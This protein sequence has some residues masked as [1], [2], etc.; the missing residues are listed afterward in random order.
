MGKVHCG[1][2]YN[3]QL[4][5]FMIVS[6]TSVYNCNRFVLNASHRSYS[7]GVE[8]FGIYSTAIK[9]YL[10]SYTM[11]SSVL[12]H[13]LL[14]GTGLLQA[15]FLRIFIYCTAAVFLLAFANW[16][17]SLAVDRTMTKILWLIGSCSLS[18]A[19]NLVF[20]RNRN[21]K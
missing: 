21:C 2:A 1:G 18:R 5:Q 4:E 12:K 3:F 19:T 8:G 16:P 14:L 17:F 6:T 13:A 20:G 10:C 7:P 15:V 11:M 9:R